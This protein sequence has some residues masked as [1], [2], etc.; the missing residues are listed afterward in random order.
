MLKLKMNIKRNAFSLFIY[1]LYVCFIVYFI[2]LTL[3]Y[4]LVYPI[5]S[6]T[7]DTLTYMKSL[8]IIAVDGIVIFI[9]LQMTN[10]L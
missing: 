2:S 9:Y 1:L 8:S 5:V 4:P 10:K 7:E 3:V 6:T